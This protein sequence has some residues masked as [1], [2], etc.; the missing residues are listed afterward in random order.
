M[1]ETAATGFAAALHSPTVAV[2][3]RG[4][5]AARAPRTRGAVVH[6]LFVA[7]LLESEKK[8]KDVYFNGAGLFSWNIAASDF[9]SINRLCFE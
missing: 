1:P 3:R 5:L 4:T 6:V 7:P 2:G 8:R 9:N